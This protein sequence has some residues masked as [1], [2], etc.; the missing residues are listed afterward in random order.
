MTALCRMCDD[1]LLEFHAVLSYLLDRFS[2]VWPAVFCYSLHHPQS[3][4]RQRQQIGSEFFSMIAAYM[5][6]VEEAR[7]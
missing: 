2:N 5:I 7:G 4:L 1:T 3:L 6:V